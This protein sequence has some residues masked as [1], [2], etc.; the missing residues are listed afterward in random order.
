METMYPPGYHH[1]GFM[2]THA[3]GHTCIHDVH[4][5]QL[6]VAILYDDPLWSLRKEKFLEKVATTSFFTE[7]PRYFLLNRNGNSNCK[8]HFKVFDDAQTEINSLIWLLE[9]MPVSTNIEINIYVL[10]S[11]ITKKVTSAIL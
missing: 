10:L 4:D 9:T 5:V 6:N 2:E 3:L 11:R 8:I 1:N 7:I